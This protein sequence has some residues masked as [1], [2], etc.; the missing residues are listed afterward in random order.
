[1][2]LERDGAIRG[3]LHVALGQEAVAVGA[4]WGLRLDDVVV[5][6]HR[7]HHHCIAKGIDVERALAELMGRQA[8]FARGRGGSMHLVAP[9]VGVIGTN[10]I[11]GA[12]L[13]IALGAALAFAT[14]GEDR[15]A[16]CFFGEGA[17]GSG[18][19]GEAMNIAGLWGLPVVFVC[20]NNQYVELAPSRVHVAGDIYRRA[21]GYG[22]P[23]VRVDGNDVMAVRAAVGAAV[24]R[25]RSGGGPTLVEA[26]TYRWLGHYSGDQGAYMPE[27]E[28]AHWRETRDPLLLCLAHLS[29]EERRRIDE[30]VAQQLEAAHSAAAAAPEADLATLFE[31]RVERF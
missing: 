7:G 27:D 8:G 13:P 20:E 2:Q 30:R 14:R 4:C 12:G 21:E 23:G 28:V 11:V 15:V 3:P 10:G 1:M 29:D 19:F 17:A 26:V 24:D 18:N 16:V 22:F 6:T 31:D 5:S 25:A 9:D